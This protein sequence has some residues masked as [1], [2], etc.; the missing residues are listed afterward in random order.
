MERILSDD[1]KIRRAE[2]IYYRRN[3]QNINIGNKSNL[4]SKGNFKDKFFL[5][6]IIMFNIAIIV[7]AVQNKE[8]IFT[9]EFLGVLEEYNVNISTNITGF[10][11]EIISDNN[12]AEDKSE[13]NI[14]QNIVKNEIYNE[15]NG[16]I[17]NNTEVN[18]P[19]QEQ[20]SSSINEM[21]IDIGNLNAAYSFIKP[22]DVGVVSST[23]GSRES[24]YQNVTGYHTGIDL[25]ADSGTIIKA[26]MEGIVELVSKEGDYGKHLK[27]RCNNVTTLYAH[28][29]DIFVKEGQI[30]AQN[31]VIASVGST[32]NSTGP[33]LHFEIRVDDRFIDP[34]KVLI[35]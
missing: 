32:G 15:V 28:C 22:L 9:K 35:F 25:A 17:V 24:K 29:K 5:H 21:E 7:F 19:A 16:E 33:H 1:E 20:L 12:I 13:E 4:K 10:F 31:Q 6:L 30:V 11:K 23:F 8:H 34:G 2:E 14:D 18:E 3:N 27:I 26:S